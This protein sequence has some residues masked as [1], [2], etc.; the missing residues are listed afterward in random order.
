[1]DEILKQEMQK[2]LTTRILP[3]WMERMVDQENGGFYGRITGQEELIPR[4]DKGAILN[5]RILW[6]YSAAYRLLGR[7][8]YKEMAN[9][10]KRYLIDHFYD[11]EFG[12]VYWSLNYRGEP[13][14]TKKQIYA[15]GFAIYGLSE[16]HRATGDPEALMY[17]VRLFNDIESHSFDG[18]KNGY[19]EALTREWNEI[20]DM[21]LSEKDANERKTMNTHLH[22]LEPYTNLYRVWKDARLER[23]LYN[24]IGLFTEKILDKDTSHLQLF[25]DDD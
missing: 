2:E 10:A 22:I 13:L 12:G 21:R 16:F 15:I 19:C 4:A 1:M 18:L 11:S 20:A 23:Q 17:A 5:A 8:E 14:D 9:R 6:T 25:F 7:E 3:Y 24:L